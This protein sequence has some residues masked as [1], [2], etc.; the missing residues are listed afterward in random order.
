ME[1]LI[2]AL[3]GMLQTNNALRL[4]TYGESLR[5][6]GI[7]LELVLALACL[8]YTVRAFT[9]KGRPG[10]DSLTEGLTAVKANFT[11]YL[12]TYVLLYF[13]WPD[14][15]DRGLG[16]VLE[17]MERILRGSGAQRA[18]AL[19]YLLIIAPATEELFFRWLLFKAER[20]IDARVLIVLSALLFF[21]AHSFTDLGKLAFGLGMALLYHRHRRIEL[22]I[23]FHALSN[24]IALGA[25]L[26][27]AVFSSRQP[28][29]SPAGALLLLVPVVIP[30]KYWRDALVRPLRVRDGS[31]GEASLREEPAGAADSPAGL[32][33]A[34]P[35]LSLFLQTGENR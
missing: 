34:T 9:R 25:A 7:G 12:L 19:A 27:W 22:N 2:L 26:A 17:L 35:V 23:L 6:L 10:K 1:Y 29:V 16:Y 5:V 11:F 8:F 30:Y 3:S 24:L 4:W 18:D 20:K 15:F 21:A 14:R 28:G 31:R 32:G 33:P 13:L